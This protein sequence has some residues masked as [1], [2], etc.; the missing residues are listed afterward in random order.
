MLKTGK[1]VVQLPPGGYEY[2]YTSCGIQY[3]GKINLPHSAMRIHPCK[4]TKLLI[5]N[6]TLTEAPGTALT[7]RLDGPIKYYFVL[8]QPQEKLTIQQGTYD[9]ILRGCGKVIQSGKI[10][11][12]TAQYRW[13]IHCSP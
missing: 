11:F 3:S 9:Y 1:N 12:N 5:K 8:T 10:K 6:Y 7:L 2:K 13:P 4:T